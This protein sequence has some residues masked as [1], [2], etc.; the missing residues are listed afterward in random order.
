MRRFEGK[1][2]GCE[3]ESGA[4]RLA[5]VGLEWRVRA[6]GSR[7][8]GGGTKKRYNLDALH[9]SIQAGQRQWGIFRSTP[10]A[11]NMLLRRHDAAILFLNCLSR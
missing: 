6:W 7:S 4:A 2:Q 11:R 3:E 10:Y 9:V 1:L 8:R 5:L